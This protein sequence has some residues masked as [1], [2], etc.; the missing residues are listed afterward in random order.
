MH[1]RLRWTE[2][3]GRGKAKI[4]KEVAFKIKPHIAQNDFHVE[5]T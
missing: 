3:D 4:L 1:R 5:S 2:D